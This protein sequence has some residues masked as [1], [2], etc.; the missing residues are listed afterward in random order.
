MNLTLRDHLDGTPVKGEM[1]VV[2]FSRFDRVRMPYEAGLPEDDMTK[3][4]SGKEYQK[5]QRLACTSSN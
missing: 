2:T 1:L 4:F 5:F 3:D